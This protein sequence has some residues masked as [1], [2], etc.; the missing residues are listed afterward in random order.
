ME[1]E[2]ASF[3]E[4][5]GTG[6]TKHGGELKMRI[7]FWLGIQIQSASP[8]LLRWFGKFIFLENYWLDRNVPCKIQ[9]K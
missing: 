6:E 2:E 4:F 3:T 8:F 5:Q 7:D 9:E 1:E